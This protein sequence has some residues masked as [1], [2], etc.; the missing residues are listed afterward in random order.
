MSTIIEGATP[1]EG[2]TVSGRYN[3]WAGQEIGHANPNID[4]YAKLINNE[5]QKLENGEI[6]IKQLMLSKR[7]LQSRNKKFYSYWK[8]FLCVLVVGKVLS[9]VFHTQQYQFGVY[10][11]RMQL[12]QFHQKFPRNNLPYQQTKYLVLAKAY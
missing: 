6:D 12:F 11:H 1:Y 10:P 8:L 2:T 4:A 9:I 7:T 5:F 3:W